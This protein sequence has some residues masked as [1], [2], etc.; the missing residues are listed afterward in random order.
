VNESLRFPKRNGTTTTYLSEPEVATVYRARF[1]GIQSRF[2]DLARYERDLLDRLD[3]SEQTYAVVT[4][5]P[6]LG[7]SFAI[8]VRSMREFQQAVIDREPLILNRGLSWHRVSVGRRRLVADGTLNSGRSRWLACELHESGA[9]SFAAAVVDR[10]GAT[11][12]PATP[13]TR[14]WST[15]CGAGCG[16]SPGTP[17]TGQPPVGAHPYGRLSGLF[18]SSSLLGSC[19]TASMESRRHSG[20]IRSPV[21]LFPK[22][23][24]TSTT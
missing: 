15:S 4:L 24:L 19:T 18:P 17:A 23:S 20:N 12:R 7:G 11:R 13:T 1:V 9:G 10:R 14:T 6:D 5:V 22:A 2:D 16:S 8:D 3:P 21:H